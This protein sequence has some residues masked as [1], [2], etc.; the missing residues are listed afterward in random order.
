MYFIMLSFGRPGAYD[1]NYF[2]GEIQIRKTLRGN[3][4]LKEWAVVFQWLIYNSLN[5]KTRCHP[6]PLTIPQPRRI[7]STMYKLSFVSSRVN[8]NNLKRLHLLNF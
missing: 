7:R 1:G 6:R 5:S 3:E 2:E 4:S 8:H